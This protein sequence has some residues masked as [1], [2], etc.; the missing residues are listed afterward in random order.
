MIRTVIIGSGNIAHT[1]HIPNIRRSGLA[2]LHGIYNR[3]LEHSRKDAGELGCKAY[4]CL[5]EIWADSCVDAVIICTPASTHCR[6]TLAALAAGKHVLCE[7]PM[8]VTA[9]EAALM[10]EASDNAEAKLMVSHNQRYYGPHIKA[11]E[12]L[13]AGVIGIV[14]NVRSCL[15]LDLPMDDACPEDYNAASEVLSH[16]IDLMHYLLSSSV[17]GVTARLTRVDAQGRSRYVT[18]GDD[19]AMAILQYENGVIA[20]LTA[21]RVS[22]NGN[23]RTTRIFGTKGS[24]T[25]YG[26]KAPVCVELADGQTEYFCLPDVPS[27]REV[28]K[29]LVDEAFFQCILNGGPPPVSARDGLRVMEVVDAVYRSKREGRYI[30][31]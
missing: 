19:T 27:Q 8:S 28:E 9:G 25:L 1:R 15:G 18:S 24:I 30:E 10:L 21:S 4:T 6:Y 20:S 11:R 2:V 22:Y 23:D 3:S 31:I 5:D 29:T 7:K 26:Q 13:D 16:R 14:L 17:S 12:L